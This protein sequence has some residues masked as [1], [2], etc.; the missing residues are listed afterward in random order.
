MDHPPTHVVLSSFEAKQFTGVAFNGNSLIL[1]IILTPLYS[2]ISQTVRTLKRIPSFSR[3]DKSF[4]AH[5]MPRW[6]SFW[7]AEEHSGLKTE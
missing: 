4:D 3:L 6:S 7:S 1:V 5:V 2:S